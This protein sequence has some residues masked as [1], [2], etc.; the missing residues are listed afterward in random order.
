MSYLR[1]QI[2][3]AV[4]SDSRLLLLLFDLCLGELVLLIV[5]LRVDPYVR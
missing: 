5:P 3:S 4:H 2:C 1:R